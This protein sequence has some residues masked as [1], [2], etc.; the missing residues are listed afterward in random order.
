[1]QLNKQTVDWVSKSGKYFGCIE[2][3]LKKNAVLHLH[4]F[5]KIDLTREN[6]RSINEQQTY[7]YV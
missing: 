1:M 2:N 6:I 3:P 5:S 7:R 4:L